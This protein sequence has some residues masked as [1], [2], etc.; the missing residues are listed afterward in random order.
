[1]ITRGSYLS[2]PGIPVGQGV[3]YEATSPTISSSRVHWAELS[4]WTSFAEN[5]RTYIDSLPAA[6]KDQPVWEVGVINHHLALNIWPPTNETQLGAHL[7]LKYLNLFNEATTPP[8]THTQAEIIHHSNGY[9]T[10]G[11][12]DYLLVQRV[13]PQAELAGLYAVMELKTFWKVPT[14]QLTEV[15]SGQPHFISLADACRCVSN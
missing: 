7:D 2:L 4:E 8:L 14:V 13:Q 11:E 6:E 9:R 10:I 12:P 3:P 15:V 1:M 5:V